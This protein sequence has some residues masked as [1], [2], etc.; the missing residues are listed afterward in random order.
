[1]TIHIMVNR[2]LDKQIDVMSFL[3]SVYVEINDPKSPKLLKEIDMMNDTYKEQGIFREISQEL[4]DRVA[5]INT[6]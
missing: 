3:L 1:M 4:R 5:E 6:N 2:Y